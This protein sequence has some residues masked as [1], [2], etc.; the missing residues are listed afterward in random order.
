M[1]KHAEAKL[2]S[3]V[4]TCGL[5]TG[6]AH[7][8]H[9]R[10]R[11]QLD[12]SESDTTLPKMARGSIHAQ[13]VRCGKPGCHCVRGEPHGPYY[14]LFERLG[15][16]LRKTYVS[17]ERLPEVAAAIEKYHDLCRKVN[18]GW[19]RIRSLPDALRV[20]QAPKSRNSVAD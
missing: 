6:T 15:G 11:P 12:E 4:H 2:Q 8:S 13:W 16:R 7:G 14:Y 18:T 17:R 5:G 9:G 1:A 19:T 3:E 20:A 10:Q